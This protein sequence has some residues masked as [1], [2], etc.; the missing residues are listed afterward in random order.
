MKRA[1]VVF[2]ILSMLGVGAC[3][4]EE[5]TDLPTDE[6]AVAPEGLQFEELDD[7]F[8]SGTYRVAEAAIRFEVIAGAD[9]ETMRFMTLTGQELF[10]SELQGEHRD[11]PTK[12]GM[13]HYGVALDS[14][15][16]VDDQPE[17]MQWINSAEAQ[18]VASLWRD[19]AASYEHESGPLNGLFRY[20]V[21]LE[22]AMAFD[23]DGLEDRQEANCNCYGKCGPGCFSVGSNSYC[24]KHDC[25]CRTYGAAAC[26]T[27]CFFNPK[28]PVAPCY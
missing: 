9:F 11:D 20:G 22:E 18:L 5:T 14:S 12:W 4:G 13:W 26:Y 25:C 23:R 3:G 8:A 1:T 28:C 15:R 7:T 21:H 6:P 2:V 24:R 17:L 27:W 10:R 19:I 16:T